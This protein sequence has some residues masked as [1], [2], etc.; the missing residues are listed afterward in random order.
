[1][2]WRQKIASNKYLLLNFIKSTSLILN[3]VNGYG[4][5]NSDVKT[6]GLDYGKLDMYNGGYK[7]LRQARLDEIDTTVTSRFEMN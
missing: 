6:E 7:Y 1:M 2:S 3:Y 5:S 4:I